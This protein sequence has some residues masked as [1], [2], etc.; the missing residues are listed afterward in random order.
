VFVI[1]RQTNVNVSA[2][3]SI[4]G[5]VLDPS[6]KQPIDTSQRGTQTFAAGA[7]DLCTN[8]AVAPFS[9]K[10]LAP[11]LGLRTVIERVKG[12]VLINP[13][14][15]SSVRTSQ[16]GRSFSSIREPREVAVRSLVDSR[17]GTVRLTASSNRRSGI[18]DSQFSGGVFQVLQS[19][20]T[21][22]KGLTEVRLKGASFRSCRRAKGR[23]SS[24]VARKRTIRRLRGNGRGRFRTRGRF[25]A[26][27]VRGT[28]WT[29]EDRCD[30]TLT[31]VKRG[32][33]A[34][35]DFRRHKTVTVKAGKS[36]LARAP[37]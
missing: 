3:D 11:S 26:A 35:R 2:T 6:G 5:L 20:K 19:R 23:R 22:A 1:K 25:S 16:K 36:Y 12:T 29:V 34:V 17:K 9:Y 32:K 8:K 18:Q 4:S 31:S 27:T 21:S 7:V 33:V 15:S 14:G 28:I 30:G 10:V 13:A 37:R 24:T